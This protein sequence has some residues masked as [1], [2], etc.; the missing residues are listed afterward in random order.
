MSAPVSPRPKRSPKR[1]RTSPDFGATPSGPRRVAIYLRRSTDDEHQ[2]FSISAQDA[3]LGRYVTTQPGW[4]L[5]A[6]FTDDAPGATTERPGLQQALRAARA[7]RFDV[8]LVYRVDRFS[9]RLSDLLGLLNELEE[10]G[11]A[12][13]SATEPFD[14][15][16]SIGRMLVQLLGVFA[17]FERETII[18]RVTKGMA[19]KASKGKWPGGS[20]PYG[21]YVDR[22]THKLI[23][24]PTE[25]PHLREIFRLFTEQRLGTRAIADE[26]NRRG[27]TNR[28]GK[29]WSGHTINRI[30]A[31]PAYTGDIVYGDVYVEDAHEPLISREVWRKACAIAASRADAHTQ[32]AMSDT[33]YHLTGLIT[34]PVCGHKY[35]GTA[36]TGRNRVYRY[37]TCFSRSRYGTHGCQA[38]RLPADALDTAILGGLADF[39]TSHT[40]LIADAITR[41]QQRYRDG[42]AG[43]RAEHAALLAQIKQKEAAIDRYFTAFE[44]GTMTE[45][46]VGQRLQVLRGEI[47]QLTA[48]TDELTDTIG[49]EPAPPP[50]GL[51]EQLQ[52]HLG[53]VIT[54]GT[55]AER[56]A[57]IEA[58]IA[59]IRITE[60]GV[61]PVFRIPGPHT[62]IPGTSHSSGAEETTPTGDPVR[63]MGWSVGP[64]GF[65]PTLS[66]T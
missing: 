49:T 4:T 3:A 41:A 19:M 46:T 34:C 16:T 53:N 33:D 59:E 36:A 45:E 64:V 28:T 47:I 29:P 50:P 62:P 22:D 52:A 66:G 12:F 58:F 14:T 15:S 43:R 60:E 42:H 30:I 20:R 32:R 5:V 56:K 17:E 63:A 10:A 61:I 6:T 26:L 31:N 9:R 1:R 57:A 23:P 27:V 65:E 35:I 7:G 2:P 44:N 55:P 21:Y 8:L 24:Y 37:Y 11:V 54:G 18:D 13:A 39:Y 38:Q 48:R 40:N 51:I 25:A